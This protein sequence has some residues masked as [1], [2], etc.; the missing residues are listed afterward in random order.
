[1]SN[2]ITNRYN[3]YTTEY[4]TEEGSLINLDFGVVRD[5][6]AIGNNITDGEIFNYI[7]LCE[8]QKLNPFLKECYL[9]KWG[10]VAQI[11]TSK[12]VFTKRLDAHPLCEGWEAGVILE[13]DG[14]IIERKGTF[15]LKGIEKLVGAFFSTHRK[16][17]KDPFYWSVSFHE[18]YRET[19]DKDSKKYKP[20][21]QWGD[22]PA[23]MITKCAI[24]SG[25]RN[26]FPKSFNGMYGEEEMGIE[27]DNV[28]VTVIDDEE[29]SNKDNKKSIAGAVEIDGTVYL[30]NDQRKLL[31][32]T[33]KSSI[34]EIKIDGYKLIKHILEKMIKDSIL[35]KD[36]KIETIPKNKVND[37][38]SEIEEYVQKKEKVF[39]KKMLLAASN[40]N[41]EII[42]SVINEMINKNL[43][44]KNQDVYFLNIDLFK[45]VVEEI[46]KYVSEENKKAEEEAK[47]EAKELFKEDKTAQKETK[48]KKQDDINI[49][50][51]ELPIEK[52]DEGK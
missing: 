15:Y 41:S 43:L 45:K 44:P 39:K 14:E 23:T 29:K 42:Q 8:Y 19:Y 50:I 10:K 40:N 16:G 37:V 49:N 13:K 32:A 26:A 17:W 48:N 24:T 4:Q 18:Y 21:G 34:D 11:V 47:E 2:E 22:M 31:F 28:N 12:D 5:V 7:K 35:P 36:T 38:K 46:K 20:M 51:S 25:S 1:M 52:L 33:A 30:N 6:L 3:T 9:I 27:L